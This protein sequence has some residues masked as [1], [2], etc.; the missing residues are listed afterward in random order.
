VVGEARGVQ[1]QGYL[2]NTPD[3]LAVDA[4]TAAG[5]FICSFIAPGGI[6]YTPVDARGRLVNN[7]KVDQPIVLYVHTG[8]ADAWSFSTMTEP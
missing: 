5:Q 1:T 8:R 6:W 7:T 4:Y 3:T 2:G